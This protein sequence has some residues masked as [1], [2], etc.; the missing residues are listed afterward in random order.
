MI[1]WMIIYIHTSTA[2]E[3]PPHLPREA[4]ICGPEEAD[5]GDVEQHHG[6]PLQPQP[7]GPRLL[8]AHPALLQDGLL[9]HAATQHLQPL[10]LHNPGDNA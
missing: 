3:Q 9:G 2:S 4:L 8:V 6:Q 7:E 10:P 1:E 5:V